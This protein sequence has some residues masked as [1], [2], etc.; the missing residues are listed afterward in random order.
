VGNIAPD[1]LFRKPVNPSQGPARLGEVVI[2][3]RPA[4]TGSSSRI[5]TFTRQK[6]TLPIRMA[7]DRFGK[8]CTL[9]G[10]YRV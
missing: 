5:V 6:M 4:I 2:F 9:N 1:A 3:T 10:P 8:R 7:I